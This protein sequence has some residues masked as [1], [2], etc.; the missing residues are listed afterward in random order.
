MALFYV[1][2]SPRDD[3][4]FNVVIESSSMGQISRLLGWNTIC[5]LASSD[6]MLAK[7]FAEISVDQEASVIHLAA[8]GNRQ[9]IQLTDQ[10]L[11]DWNKLV[12]IAGDALMK[13]LIVLSACESEG[14]NG[15]CLAMANAG[16]PAI[17]VVGTQR[18]VTY[19]EAAI[20][21]PL[22]YF[23]VKRAISEGRDIKDAFQ[24]S[25]KL[26]NAV[27]GRFCSYHRWDEIENKFFRFDRTAEIDWDPPE[28]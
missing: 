13:K 15:F 25:V 23:S 10:S 19:E 3:E 22:F 11:I 17:M 14:S 2:E 20:G 7:A 18:T 1:I 16:K 27:C 8:H 4:L 6:L 24:R 21:W 12:E 26:V 9:G 5:R 28:D